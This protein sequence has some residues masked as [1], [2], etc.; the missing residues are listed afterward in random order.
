MKY[1]YISM[2]EFCKVK[3][4]TLFLKDH[5]KIHEFRWWS[6]SQSYAPS[7]EVGLELG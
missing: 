1:Q 4:P 3:R 5:G 6:V 7:G 2:L